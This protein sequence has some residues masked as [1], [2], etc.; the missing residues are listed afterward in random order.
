[1]LCNRILPRLPSVIMLLCVPAGVLSDEQPQRQD[2]SLTKASTQLFELRVRPILAENC[3]SC[4]GAEKQ[5][6]NLRLD[7]AAHLAR[8]G[9][10][11]AVVVPGDP[12]G[13]LLIQA[14]RHEGYEM[15]PSGKLSP[16]D[17]AALEQWV[18]AGAVWPGHS[19]PLRPAATGPEFTAEDREWWALEPVQ[20]PSLPDL[21]SDWIQNPIDQFLLQQ[22]Q[23]SGLKP[24]PE[25]DKRTLLRR[26]T[27]GLSGLPPTPEQITRFLEDE[28]PEA[29]SKLVDRLL[30]SP[31]YGERWGR[32]WLDVVRYADSDGYRADGYRPDAWRY[33][34]YVIRSLNEDKPYNRF[35]QEQLAGDE[36][37]PDDPDAL[38]ATGF[39]RHWIYEYNN[40]DARGQWEIILNEI[41]DTTG[42]VFLGLGMQC[43]RCHDHKFDPILQQ[44][45]FRLRAFFEAIRPHDEHPVAST[46]EFADWQEQHQTW[47]T[48]TAEVR[49]KIASLE[50][51]YRERAQDKAIRMFPADVQDVLRADPDQLP[52]HEAQIHHLAWRQVDFEFGRLPIKGKDAETLAELKRQLEQYSD[53]KPSAL[54]T[55]MVVSDIG[56]QAP[57]TIIPK[58]NRGVE[59]GVLTILDQPLPT[60]QPSAGIPGLNPTTGRR[61]ALARWLTGPDNPLTPRVIVNRIWQFH[62]GRGLAANASDLGILGGPPSHPEL[63]NWLTREFLDSGWSMKH[64]HRLIV[65]S[66]AYR[67]SSDHPEMQRQQQL[68]PDNL[69]YWRAEIRRMDAEQIRD[70]I[71]AISGQLKT[72]SG[73][74][75]VVSDDSRRS[76]YLRYLR[77]T[78]DPLMDAFDLPQFFTSTSRRD[79]T[80]SPVQSLLLLNSPMM[81][82]HA[83]QLAS[84]LTH[85]HPQADPQELAENLWMLAFGRQASPDEL[86]SAVDFLTS[87]SQTLQQER[88]QQTPEFPTAPL[89]EFPGQGIN[90]SP[91]DNPI[92]LS[93]TSLRTSE[94]SEFTIESMFVLRSV[95]KSGSVRTIASRWNGKSDTRGWTF[96]VTGKGSRRK[97]QTLV[98][99]MFGPDAAGAV[100]E[101]ALFSDHH[102]E[103]NT[104]YYAAVTITPATDSDAGTAVF[105]LKN[106]LEQEQP[107]STVT[108]EHQIRC[109]FDSTVPFTIGSRS[110]GGNTFFDGLLDN[111]RLTTTALD[112]SQLLLNSAINRESTVGLWTF[113]SS[114]GVLT[115]SVDPKQRLSASQGPAVSVTPEMAALTDLCHTLLNSSEFLY[116]R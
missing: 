75:G 25:T 59:P 11:G 21:K 96:G 83:K 48:A 16:G 98:L 112:K 56:R 84:R 82:K 37:F 32:H 45:Y 92:R 10:S 68:D 7:T 108:L 50:Q 103:L 115:N 77:N 30:S 53:R 2:D 54:P 13:S 17:I 51:P 27:L 70:S 64:V 111:I 46:A 33:R 43:A 29:Y 78:R 15:P 44:D 76:V 39:L 34:D 22:M 41:T 86:N 116:V 24:A 85:D 14:V 87:Q 66:A 101:A 113:E 55:A 105:H 20:T 95:F 26:V 100:V 97:P 109:Q 5:K 3:F 73:G 61:S 67:Q 12:D 40:R 42:D 9:E 23:D 35:V 38:I 71:L 90:V 89:A 58:K 57:P 6:G 110:G 36:L 93:A 63:L 106:L 99:Q 94:V 62:F 72:R 74:P 19:V 52:P 60:L 102:V 8:G 104:P 107:L 91:N 81:L 28:S 114:P 65:M 49:E 80:T 79:T 18:R 88:D 31:Q 47:L 69:H 4:H 1:M